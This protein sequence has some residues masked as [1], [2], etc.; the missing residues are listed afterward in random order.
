MFGPIIPPSLRDSEHWW[1]CD[2]PPGVFPSLWPTVEMLRGWLSSVGTSDITAHYRHVLLTAHITLNTARGATNTG[3][4]DQMTEAERRS[5]HP[6]WCFESCLFKV[7][8]LLYFVRRA[9]VKNTGEYNREG[10]SC[11]V[12][13]VLFVY[14][15]SPSYKPFMSKYFPV[16]LVR[17]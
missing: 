17:V 11:R 6:G 13:W 5:T 1:S 16:T 7:A 3:E 9:R 2:I 8:L 14:S 4:Y 15:S 10:A 12:L